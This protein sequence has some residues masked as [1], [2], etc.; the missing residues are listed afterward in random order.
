MMFKKVQAQQGATQLTEFILSKVLS[1]NM[2]E[3]GILFC[4]LQSSLE[5]E[6]SALKLIFSHTL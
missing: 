5:N 1:L 4:K 3:C 6:S 2:G